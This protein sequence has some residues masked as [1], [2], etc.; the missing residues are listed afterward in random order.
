MP[1]TL[2]EHGG[3]KPPWRPQG[4]PLLYTDWRPQRS[5]VVAG[6]APA[7]SPCPRHEVWLDG[8][9]DPSLP[10]R[11]T[12]LRPLR[13]EPALERSEKILRCAQD[14]SEGTSRSGRGAQ[15]PSGGRCPPAE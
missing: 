10:L 9:R 4:S 7:M 5:I 13:S 8:R 3:G 14:D 11:M 15:T 12:L 1:V 2:R 6:L